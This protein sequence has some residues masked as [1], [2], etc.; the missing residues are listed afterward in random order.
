MSKRLLKAILAAAV[1]FAAVA[2]VLH[3]LQV[4]HAPG[5][6]PIYPPGAMWN[7]PVAFGYALVALMKVYGRPAWFPVKQRR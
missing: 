6:L 7:Y 5:G 3:A 1:V 2:L 4:V